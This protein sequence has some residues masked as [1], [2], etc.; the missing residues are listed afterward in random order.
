MKGIERDRWLR[1][2]IVSTMGMVLLLT[3]LLLLRRWGR[4]CIIR[5]LLLKWVSVENRVYYPS[6]K[7]NISMIL[8]SLVEVQHVSID[9]IHNTWKIKKKQS[10]YIP[11]SSHKHKGRRHTIKVLYRIWGHKQGNQHLAESRWGKVSRKTKSSFS[12]SDNKDLG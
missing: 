9:L 1:R 11:R 4:K 3:L 6:N 12:F 5:Y 10:S 2:H 7:S 8:A